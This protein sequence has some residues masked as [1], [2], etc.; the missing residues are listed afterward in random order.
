MR[1]LSVV[2]ITFNEER[3]IGRCIDSVK[4][5]AD[6]IVVVDSY[7]TD[8]TAQICREKNVRVIQ[9]A[10]EGYI[11]QKNWA[12]TQ[13]IYPF[14]L[15]LD[16]DEALSEEL[17]KSVDAAKKNKH[18]A[19]MMNRLTNYCGKWIRHGGWYPDRKLRLFD[20]SVG[21]WGGINPHD[22]F[23]VN[24]RID[25]GYLKGDILHYS[26]YTQEDH[27]RQIEKFSD[28][29]A[30]ALYSKGVRFYYWQLVFKP[31]ARFLKTYIANAGFMD[32]KEGWIIAAKSAKATY[33][34]YS[35]LRRLDRN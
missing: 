12:L 21:K 19:Y 28:I 11:E 10:F 9:H 14:V 33:L 27:D 22:K 15:S 3:N 1:D 34:R 24:R 2:I 31:V 4:E 26:Y 7:S 23:E 8:N 17:L 16:A 32:G 20:K 18:K 29:A 30:K 13:S 5:I 6:D 25:V 35:K